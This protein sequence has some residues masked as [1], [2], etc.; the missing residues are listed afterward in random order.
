[1]SLRSRGWLAVAGAALSLIPFQSAASGQVVTYPPYPVPVSVSPAVVDEPDDAITVSGQGFPQGQGCA[2]GI[3]LAVPAGQDVSGP[4]VVKFAIGVDLNAAGE[5][6]GFSYTHIAHEF[7]LAVGTYSIVITCNET[8]STT[9]STSA[10]FTVPVGATVTTTTTT[11]PTTSTS[12]TLAPV[13]GS[14]TSSTTTV[15]SGTT[16]TVDPSTAKPGVTLTIR[17][18]GFQADAQLQISLAGPP[19]TALGSTVAGA[20][21]A[22]AATLKLPMNVAPGSHTLL[23]TGPGPDGASRST[24]ATITVQD[25]NCSDFT[26][27]EAANAALGPAGADPHGLD[28]DRDGVACEELSSGSGG[29]AGGGGGGGTSGASSGTAVAASGALPQTGT[30][31]TSMVVMGGLAAMTLGALLVGLSHPAQPAGGQH[32]RRRTRRR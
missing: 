15:G 1:M 31:H 8:S 24:T 3:I 2:P 5:P 12:T 28:A 14:T 27:S 23:V 19:A 29:G 9:Y 6:G 10:T 22:Y 20:S 16:G 4:G 17:G 32:R 11:T 30:G 13:E 7:P 21:G 26:T 25:L 18:S